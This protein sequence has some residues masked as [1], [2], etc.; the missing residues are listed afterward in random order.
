MGNNVISKRILVLGATG[1]M[2]EPVARHL[3]E[4]GFLVRILARDVVK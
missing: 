1:M 3:Q 2:G 4:A